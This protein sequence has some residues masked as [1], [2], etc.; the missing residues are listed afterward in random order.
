MTEWGFTRLF[1]PQYI[2][3]VKKYMV[4]KTTI[5]NVSLSPGIPDRSPHAKPSL[6]LCRTLWIA[7]DA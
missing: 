7:A 6:P 2:D 1:G 3:R 5:V 4:E